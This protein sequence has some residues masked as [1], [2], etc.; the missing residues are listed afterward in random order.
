LTVGI[1][2]GHFPSQLAC[3]D[4]EI[5]RGKPCHDVNLSILA[6]C[7]NGKTDFR[8]NEKLGI[9]IRTLFVSFRRNHRPS[10]NLLPHDFLAE[11]K[12][13][14]DIQPKPFRPRP[15]SLVG[16]SQIANESLLML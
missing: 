6:I 16:G 12:L 14:Q 4:V 13:L 15:R 1:I 10:A 11:K 7:D 2:P 3:G 8:H 5:Y 9:Q